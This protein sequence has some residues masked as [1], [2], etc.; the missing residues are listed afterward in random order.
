MKIKLIYY[1][2]P[3][4][5]FNI[6]KKEKVLELSTN[7]KIEDILI[8]FHAKGI[9]KWKSDKFGGYIIGRYKNKGKLTNNKSYFILS[10]NILA[11]IKALDNL[12]KK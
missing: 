9:A 2:S 1:P 4:N 12:N 3:I 11:T 7:S 5:C 8:K 10:K 6:I